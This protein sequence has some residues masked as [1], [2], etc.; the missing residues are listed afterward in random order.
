MKQRILQIVGM[1]GVV[2]CLVIFIRKPSFPTPD[3]LLV[4]LTFIFIAWGRAKEMLKRLVPFVGL[5][6]VYESFRGIVPHINH[7]VEFKWMPMVDKKLF[8][9][10]PTQT[11]Q[12]WL[13]HG[14]V[15]WYDFVF[16]LVY[17]V[18]FIVPIG[19][20]LLIWR[21]RDHV[22]WRFVT[23]YLVTSFMGFI[24]FLA[25]P[26][27]PPWM[28]SDM[29]IIPH[30]TRI[31]S[32]VWFAL[33]KGVGRTRY[34]VWLYPALI[35]VGTVYQGEHYAIDAI[36]GSIYALVA[37]F[38]LDKLWPYLPAIKNRFLH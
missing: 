22:Y 37:Y 11:L 38:A 29:N 8:H 5:L 14:H 17:M 7:R 16:Y 35:Y 34:L 32:N 4:F 1:V 2:V 12:N 15:Q 13:W 26:A 19:L 6:L 23:T 18:H 30:I 10:L 36:I 24:T 9:S 31:S 20:A 3:K 25:F 21:Y 27:A 33:F 28:A